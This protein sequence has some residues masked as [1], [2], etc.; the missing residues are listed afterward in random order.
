M[1]SPSMPFLMIAG[2]WVFAMAPLIGPMVAAIIL[3]VIISLIV[4]I[5]M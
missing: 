5:C 1:R 4:V 2:V 3:A